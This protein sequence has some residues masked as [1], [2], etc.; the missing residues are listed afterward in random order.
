MHNGVNAGTA[1]HKDALK[2]WTPE[3]TSSNIPR[4]DSTWQYLSSNSTRWLVSAKYFSINNISIGYTLPTKFTTRFGINQLR[5]YGAAD[6]VA[7]WSARKGLD[8]RQSYVQS[9]A[10][11]Y[12]A[13][14]AISGGVKVVF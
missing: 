10:G 3:N 5:V 2:A 1:M 12:S 4:L 13:L 11:S 6:N 14:R 8:P 9:Y 7:L